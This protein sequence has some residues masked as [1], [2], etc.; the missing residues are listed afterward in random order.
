LTEISDDDAVLAELHEQTR[1]LRLLGLQALKPL[2]DKVLKTDK[3]RLAYE[4]T[5]GK[6]TVREVA[7]AAGVSTG[8]VSKLWAEWTAAGICFESRQVAGRAEHLASLVSLGYRMPGVGEPGEQQSQRGPE[9]QPL[10][11]A[12]SEAHLI[13]ARPGA[14]VLT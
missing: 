4:L 7:A 1:W 2:L 5:D 12:T 11:E 14:D 6:R 3:H 10:S 9:R 8:T 13:D